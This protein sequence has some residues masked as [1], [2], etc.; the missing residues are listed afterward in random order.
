MRRR[1][2]FT[3]VEVL[4]AAA[5]GLTFLLLLFLFQSRGMRVMA[6]DTRKLSAVGRAHGAS[7]RLRGE[8]AASAWS[9]VVPLKDGSR[10][11]FAALPDWLL[12]GRTG[13]DR[14]GDPPRGPLTHDLGTGGP[15]L[16][17]GVA[18]APLE[19]FHDEKTRTLSIGPHAMKGFLAARFQHASQHVLKYALVADDSHE[20]SGFAAERERC[21]LVGAVWLQA[22][23]EDDRYA[24]IVADPGH[25]WCTR[26]VPVRTGD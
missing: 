8:L 25:E 15:L 20:S 18:G 7:E 9:W 6:S 16:Y 3:L 11:V 4:V 21:T 19:V 23:D 14:A 1:A 26:G 17:V 12:D 13:S 10:D 2:A 5:V 24:G 22:Q